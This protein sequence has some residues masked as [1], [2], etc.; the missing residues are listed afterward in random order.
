MAVLKMSGRPTS[1][2]K[3]EYIERVFEI[4]ESFD[5]PNIVLGFDEQQVGKAMAGTINTCWLCELSEM[6][7]SII[8]WSFTFNSQ[9]LEP[10]KTA[11]KH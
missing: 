10:V 5:Y 8:I 3:G 2:T 9:I 6:M 1:E 11:T 4:L 7:C